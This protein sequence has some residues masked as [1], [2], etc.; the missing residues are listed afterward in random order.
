MQNNKA[1]PAS[2]GLTPTQ[3][4]HFMKSSHHHLN[5]RPDQ[6][7]EY[8]EA[9]D[10]LRGIMA[11]GVVV[12]HVNKPWF[13]GAQIMMDIFF[14]ISGFLI[15]LLLLRGKEAK[16]YI[17]LKTFWINRIKRL[18]PLLLVVVSLYL[19]VGILVYEDPLPLLRDAQATLLYYSNFTKLE[20]RVYPTYFEQTWSLAIEEQFY[21]VWPILL[22][23]FK[24]KLAFSSRQLSLLLILAM[25]TV[26]A[27]RYYLID[28]GAPWSRI[29]Y[30]SDT[31]IDAFCAGALLAIIWQ[32]NMAVLKT[33]PWTNRVCFCA[34]VLLIVFVS[35]W[36]PTELHYFQWQ[37]TIIIA[38]SCLSIL[39]LSLPS[40]NIFKTILSLKWVSRL[41]LLCYGSYLWHWPLVFLL[42]SKTDLSRLEIL[43]FVF[44]ATFLLSVA[45]YLYIEFPIL[46]KRRNIDAASPATIRC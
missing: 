1:R 28:A 17:D 36:T 26:S 31:R 30:G 7:R 12:A 5:R 3:S 35:I 24:D 44:P 46:S 41:G 33:N 45:S 20:P 27:W 32:K 4:M 9:L 11:F 38:T 8:F 10:G 23:F 15:T 14:V 34:N 37:Q 25:L 29:Y 16:G 40:K 21:L 18:Y 2:V 13:P 22:M 19:C 6:P 42:T 43:Y 39:G